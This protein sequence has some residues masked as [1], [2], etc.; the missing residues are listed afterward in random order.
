MT[1]RT[2]WLRDPP[3][4]AA[5]A[6]TVAVLFAKGTAGASGIFWMD[7]SIAK[8]MAPLACDSRVPGAK[9]GD[10]KSVTASP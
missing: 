1:L 5:A 3:A 2:P 6:G 7:V 4:S 10:G 8:D 9:A